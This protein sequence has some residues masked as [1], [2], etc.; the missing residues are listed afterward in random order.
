MNKKWKQMVTV[1][2]LSIFLLTSC[3]SSTSS[4]ENSLFNPGTYTGTAQGNGGP[5][6]VTL[7][8]SET[9][10]TAIDV[11]SNESSFTADAIAEMTE[12]IM[13][14]NSVDV[15][16]ISSATVTTKA[17]KEAATF[18]YSQALNNP[19][20]GE[21][22]SQ[23]FAELSP[24][25]YEVTKVGRKGN[26]TLAITLDAKSI[27][28]IEVL[29]HRETSGIADVA[30]VDLPQDIIAQQNVN[31]DGYAGATFTSMAVKSAVKTAIR[32]AGGSISDF[33]PAQ[34]PVD[35]LAEVEETYDIIVVGGG[36][37][38][39]MAALT[40]AEAGEKVVL[41]EK[42]PYTGGN[43]LSAAGVIS[44]AGTYLHEEQGIELSPESYLAHRKNIGRIEGSPYYS[45]EAPY[46][47]R[48][49]ELNRDMVNL[50]LDRGIEFLPN[51]SGVSH[52]L[53]P[54]YF[55]GCG[56]FAAWLEESALRAGATIYK[57]TEVTELISYNGVVT[58][59]IAESKDK[60]YRVSGESVILASGGFTSNQEM[61]DN[62]YPE[63][64]RLY[65]TAQVSTLGDGLQMAEAAGAELHAMDSGVHKM[66]V[67][68]KNKIEL[69]F[70]TFF[71]P[72]IIVDAQGD[73][74]MSEAGNY[75]MNSDIMLDANMDSAYF[76]M[77]SNAYSYVYAD[78][79]G[80]WETGDALTFDSL[81][82][83]AEELGMSNI[84]ATVTRYNS[85]VANGADED[86]NRRFM[87]QPLDTEGEFYAVEFEPGL[88]MTYG[89]VKVDLHTRALTPEGTVISGLYAA[90]DVAGSFE[91][92]EG[93]RYTAGVTQA[94]SFGRLAA[95]TAIQDKQ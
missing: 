59:V 72:T 74:F 75:S 47:E 77:D 65:S 88:Y 44:G 4:T 10:I 30:L 93:L 48:F 6:I 7:T 70:M 27:V 49:F 20:A 45:E 95:E 54:G 42:L 13:D 37:A 79:P 50:L 81:Q 94:L 8:V 51:P 91:V 5:L 76:V 26:I 21:E 17:L 58:G 90:G 55:K 1:L 80:L 19:T 29:D 35:S 71:S 28:A 31:V 46:T 67:T 11:E 16:T 89:G 85:M 18:A 84:E 3:G 73:R 78:H 82:A 61:I 83:M 38:G 39:L 14:T 63:Y 9:E 25:V 56:A 57:S 24:G 33:S 41:F 86:F 36:P 22:K 32:E 64:S 60:I 52:V 43:L 2:I 62:L 68:S 87:F 23:A 69:P 92:Q 53:Q 40:A 34:K 15:D 66:Y 12:Q